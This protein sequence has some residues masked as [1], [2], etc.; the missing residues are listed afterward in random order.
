MTREK[1]KLRLKLALISAVSLL[2]LNGAIAQTKVMTLDDAI[3]HSLE[4]SYET[5]A[6][7]LNIQKANAAVKEAFGYALPSVDLS[8][9]YTRFIDKSQVPFMDFEA[10]LNN[11]TTGKLLE[12]KLIL[13]KDAKMVPMG[14]KLMSMTQYNNY[15]AKAQITQIL[16]SPAVFKGIGATESYRQLAQEQ[17][18]GKIIGNITSI[19]KAFYGVI[20]SKEMLNI[21]QVSLS[22]AQENL[23]NLQLMNGEGFTSDFEV[24]Q[25]EVQVENI[26]PQIKQ[27]EN[28]LKNAENGLKVLIGLEQGESVEFV[29]E[30]NPVE[31]DI[32]NEQGIV[33]SALENNYD[34]RTLNKKVEV[35]QAYID[36]NKA[37][38]WPQIAA[39]GSLKYAGSSDDWKFMNYS[40]SMVGVSMQMNLFNGF[41]TDKK[42]EQ[43]EVDKLV[44]KE[45]IIQLRSVVESEIKNQISEFQ[46]VKTTLE[47]QDKNV[48][49]AERAYEIANLRYKEGKGTQLEI[50]NADLELKNAKTNKLQ[51]IYDIICAKTMLDQLSGRIDDNYNKTIDKLINGGK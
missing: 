32:S 24:M 36:I 28:S 38:Y 49:L 40:E 51:S 29:G 30:L 46:R 21:L 34:I 22:N 7:V 50:K 9:G 43:S 5:K 18:K 31:T 14:N 44:T 41:R 20:L 11:Y 47:A 35:D 23:R 39:F 4:K 25:V 2:S 3:K 10:L 19:K 27:L 17:L 48:K 12:H 45:Q 33:E 42:V 26:K 8:A 15:E 6:S 37:G 1:L 13:E 16:F